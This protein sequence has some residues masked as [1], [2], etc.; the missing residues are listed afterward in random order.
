MKARFGTGPAGLA[1]EPRS[2]VCEVR[3]EGLPHAA[4]EIEEGVEQDVGRG[5]AVAADEFVAGEVGIEFCEI[6]LGDGL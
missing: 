5:V 4:G 6:V 2:Q 3:I 1:R